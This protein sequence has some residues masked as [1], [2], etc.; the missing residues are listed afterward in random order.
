MKLSSILLITLTCFAFSSQAGNGIIHLTDSNY[1]IIPYT[2][3]ESYLFKNAKVT[4][5]SKEEIQ[6]IETLLNKCIDEY[7]KQTKGQK[8]NGEYK[9]QLVPVTNKK[10]EKEVFINCFCESVFSD[11]WHEGIIRVCDG[12]SCYFNLKVNLSAKKSY[13]LMINGEA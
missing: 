11:Y 2:K 12:G 6:E 7:N 1:A 8:I 4:S 3:S 9:V 10:G 13:N 5:L